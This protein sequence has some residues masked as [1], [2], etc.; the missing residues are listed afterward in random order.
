MVLVR[1]GVMGLDIED[2]NKPAIAKILVYL[3]V[4]CVVLA[5]IG[6]MGSDLYLASTQ[7][8]LIGI[9]LGV[10]GVYILVEAYLRLNR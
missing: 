1:K 7:W 8:M 2:K 9:I 5:V 4:V 3:S 6:A 10:W